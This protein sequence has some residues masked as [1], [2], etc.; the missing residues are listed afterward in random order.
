MWRLCKLR[1]VAS[2]SPHFYMSHL[3]TNTTSLG[4]YLT[5]GYALHT[6]DVP[7]RKLA[8]SESGDTLDKRRIV[9]LKHMF[10]PEEA[11]VYPNF[12]PG[13]RME[14]GMEVERMCGP[15]EKLTVFEGYFTHSDTHTQTCL[16]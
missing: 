14:V 12:Y 4:V 2:S 16:N 10:A 15:V 1:C 7:Y 9:I 6:W 5:L 11:N 3:F 8:W 13:I